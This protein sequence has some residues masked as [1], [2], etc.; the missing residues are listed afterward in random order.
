MYRYLQM[1]CKRKTNQIK[2][3]QTLKSTLTLLFKIRRIFTHT[4]FFSRILVRI[5]QKVTIYN[6]L[7][8][9]QIGTPSFL[10][11]ARCARHIIFFPWI[12]NLSISSFKMVLE[13]YHLSRVRYANIPA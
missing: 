12:L 13:L 3:R 7:G 9:S 11:V 2:N 1:Q 6:E 5:L 8:S 10:K 4:I